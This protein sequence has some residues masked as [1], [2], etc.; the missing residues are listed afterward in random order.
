M[1][2]DYQVY[3]SGS[4]CDNGKLSARLLYDNRSG[5]RKVELTDI[6]L[7]YRRF[8]YTYVI[9]NIILSQEPVQVL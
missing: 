3:I 9:K 8:W 6:F 7:K 1:K 2:K 5:S 4:L